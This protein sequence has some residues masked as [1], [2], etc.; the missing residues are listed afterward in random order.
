MTTET[1]YQIYLSCAVVSTDTRNI[2]PGALFFALKGANF[3]GNAFAAQ[4]LTKGASHAVVDEA[5]FVADGRFLLVDN[6]LKTLQD[7]ARHHR[8]QLPVPVIAMTGSNGKTT[9]KELIQ[10]VLSAKYKTYATRGNLNNHIGLPLTLLAV[11]AETEMVVLE[12]GS[13]RPGDIAELASIC[14]PTHGLITNIGKAHLEGFGG[15]EGVKK[16][17]GELYDYFRQHGGTVFANVQ[18]PVLQQM[19]AERGLAATGYPT[20]GCTLVSSAPNVVYR[21]AQGNL[22]ETH[23]PGRHNF[24][25]IAAALCIGAHFGVPAA[26]AN[27]AVAGYVPQ[28]NRSQTITKGTNT[29]LLDAYNANP[30]SMLASLEYFAALEAGK[31]IVIL[32]DM[33]ELGEYG[34]HEHYLMGESSKRGG[35]DK[36]LLCGPLMQ[37]AVAANPDAYYFID[38]FSLNNWLTDNKIA[39]AHI[40]IKGSRRMALETLVD[41]L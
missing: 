39:N 25:N 8:R 24:E 38:K 30:T 36:V 17:E 29:I 16:G 40:L 28:N 33:A 34:A 1:L 41:L 35:F 21:D 14:E 15:F 10:R 23:L 6:V 31:K 22:A 26:Q 12:M 3:N 5:A 9:T 18:N 19:L 37:N 27:A 20:A 4:A 7:L 2:T 32:G 13:N 11:G